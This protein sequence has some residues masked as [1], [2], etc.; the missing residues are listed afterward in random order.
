M[1]VFI[2]FEASSLS[3][4]SYPVEVAWVFQDGRSESHLIAPAPEW[5][6]WDERAEAIHGIGRGML[7]AE[8]EWHDDVAARIIEAL[9]DHDL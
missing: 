6:D 9:G 1:K 4:R 3:D 5:T 2:D 7:V 8:D